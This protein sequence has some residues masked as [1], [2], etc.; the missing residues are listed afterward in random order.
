MN[1]YSEI[2]SR[3]APRHMRP[4]PARPAG[5]PVP[6]AFLGLARDLRRRLA[7]ADALV[8]AALEAAL[9]PLRTR[10]KRRPTLRADLL[11]DTERRWRTGLPAF[12]RLV[13]T[14]ER[15]R[16]VPPYFCELRAQAGGFRIEDWDEEPGGGGFE[17]G[18]LLEMILAQPYPGVGGGGVDVRQTT[19]VVVSLHALG[20]R[21][22]RGTDCSEAAIFADLAALAP[23]AQKG[24]LPPKARFAL[25]AAE[26]WWCGER[27]WVGDRLVLAVRTYLGDVPSPT[28]PSPTVLAPTVSVA[29]HG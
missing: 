14:A 29:G 28:V 19:I 13:L 24:A 4:W 2:L 10:L 17:P 21:F 20:R 5:T 15:R 12:G 16:G 6:R 8:P 26:G 9:L 7:A 18:V 11:I 27:V 23:F 3:P 25:P 1:G 22:Q